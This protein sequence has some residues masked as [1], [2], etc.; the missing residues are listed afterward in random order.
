M[1]L[2]QR[3]KNNVKNAVKIAQKIVTKSEVFCR[4]KLCHKQCSAEFFCDFSWEKI[5]WVKK[6]LFS[7]TVTNPLFSK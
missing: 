3:A 7:A 1:R 6:F 4:P 2:K 5:S